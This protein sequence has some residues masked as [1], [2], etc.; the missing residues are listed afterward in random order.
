MANTFK[1]H[2]ALLELIRLREKENLDSF[3]DKLYISLINDWKEESDI[4]IEVTGKQ[5]TIL[6][7]IEHF[8]QKE[9]YEKCAVLKELST[10]IKSKS[11]KQK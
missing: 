2:K 1:F 9:E 6:M 4:Q 11:S 7:M 3:I 8:I 5:T 10:F